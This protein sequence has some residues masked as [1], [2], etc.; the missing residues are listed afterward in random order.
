MASLQSGD[1][2]QIHARMVQLK[3]LRQQRDG[4]AAK[5]NVAVQHFGFDLMHGAEHP[6]M[7]LTVTAQG[8]VIAHLHRQFLGAK[9]RFQRVDQGLIVP[10]ELMVGGAR[11]LFDGAMD[12]VMGFAHHSGDSICAPPGLV[13]VHMVLFRVCAKIQ[14]VCLTVMTLKSAVK[15]QEYFKLF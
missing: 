3:P 15:I 10:A 6:G 4:M 13:D 14:Q 12:A 5:G 2:G 8:A 1:N 7:L 9:R 11:Q